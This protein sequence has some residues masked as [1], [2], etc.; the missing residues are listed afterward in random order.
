[1]KDT[2]VGVLSQP[3]PFRYTSSEETINL[4]VDYILPQRRDVNYQD[5]ISPETRVVAF[6]ERHTAFAQI[7]ELIKN[8]QLFKEMGFTHLLL[9]YFSIDMQKDLDNYFEAKE[10]SAKE[11]LYSILI[12]TAFRLRFPKYPYPNRVMELLEAAKRK[13]IRPIALEG[14]YTEPRWYWQDSD[15]AYVAKKILE[16]DG[17]NKILSLTGSSHINED[18]RGGNYSFVGRLRASGYAVTAIFILEKYD[19]NALAEE[20]EYG[21]YGIMVPSQYSELLLYEAIYADLP[22]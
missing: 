9:E 13:G 19:R 20:V 17:N 4:V 5:M 8:M 16:S 7:D 15:K 3:K 22:L 18:L 21:G 14:N 10:G 2:G 6:G 11:W 12:D 1:M